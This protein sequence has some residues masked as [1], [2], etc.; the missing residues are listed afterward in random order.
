MTNAHIINF[1]GGEDII[2]VTESVELPTKLML[3]TACNYDSD[4]FVKEAPFHL[5]IFKTDI[6]LHIILNDNVEVLMGRGHDEA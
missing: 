2:W 5:S 3:E 4:W 6:I 1:V